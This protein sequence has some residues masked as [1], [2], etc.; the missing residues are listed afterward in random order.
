MYRTYLFYTSLL[1]RVFDIKVNDNLY[2]FYLFLF[3]RHI[4]I[5]LYDK[6]H[7]NSC[8]GVWRNERRI[9][10]IY[11]HRYDRVIIISCRFYALRNITFYRNY[12]RR[13][14]NNKCINIRIKTFSFWQLFN[15]TIRRQ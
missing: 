4:K 1:F 13:A 11:L 15:N 10:I 12:P 9:F 5:Y 7:T 6:C 2:F 14:A 8:A 3:A